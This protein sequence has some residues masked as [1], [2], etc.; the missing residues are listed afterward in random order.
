MGQKYNILEADEDQANH[1]QWPTQ[2]RDSFMDRVAKLQKEYRTDPNY[3]RFRQHMPFDMSADPENV[4]DNM[5]VDDVPD[6]ST[7]E[8]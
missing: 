5:Q 6:M 2:V 4:D 8:L 7:H 3:T 1:K